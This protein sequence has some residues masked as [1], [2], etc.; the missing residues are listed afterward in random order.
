[1]L[2]SARPITDLIVAVDTGSS[3]QTILDIKEFGQK[4]NIPTY[5]F[6]RPFDNFG[7]SRNYA[8]QKLREVVVNL[9]WDLEETWMFSIDCDEVIVLSREFDRKS[10]QKNYYI[11]NF[12]LDSS[13][14]TRQ[15]FM[16]L[17]RNFWW[18]GPIHEQIA[19]EE[20]DF[21]H[22]LISG[23]HIICY[24]EGASWKIDKEQKFLH[25]AKLLTDYIQNGHE[26]FRWVFYAGES[27]TAAANHTKMKDRKKAHTLQAKMYYEWATKLDCNT[28]DK[29]VIVLFRIA[30][31][32]IGLGEPWTKI[33]PLYWQCL[34]I[35]SRRAESVAEMITYYSSTGHWNTASLLSQFSIKNWH[36]RNP[37]GQDVAEINESLY[38]WR[39]LLHHAVS[40]YYL[41]DKSEARSAYRAVN[42]ITETN[43]DWFSPSDIMYIKSNSPDNLKL[44]K[45]SPFNI[46]KRSEHKLN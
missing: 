11:A 7:N 30:E 24:S 12:K 33:K 39:L 2:E 8:L 21:T 35:D 23:L 6:E 28:A 26:E 13:S 43:P 10:I 46:M 9:N 4:Y 1:M 38:N 44:K 40:R 5:V 20:E 36:R 41:G 25:Y 19:S 18:E 3:D 37:Y 31:K 15:F 29:A 16:R 42:M 27:F 45:W 14:F 34:L 32:M 22:D 17:S